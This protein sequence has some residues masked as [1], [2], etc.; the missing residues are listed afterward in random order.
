MVYTASDATPDA[1]FAISPGGA[2]SVLA[3]GD[4]FK[5]LDVFMTRAPGGDLIICDNSSADV[6]YRVDPSTG[7]L[8]IFLTEAQILAAIG[9]PGQTDVDLEGGIAFD[10]Q[11]YFYL[12]EEDSDN[13]G[14]FDSSGNGE[15]FVSGSD[16]GAA[17]GEDNADLEAGIAFAPPPAP[18][19]RRK[20][21]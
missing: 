14:K 13:I 17:T 9:Y 1:I 5:D 7:D 19:W 6:V 21:Q 8:S 12:A 11:G 4:P 10:S 18:A 2:P 16:M 3:S 15:I 20:W